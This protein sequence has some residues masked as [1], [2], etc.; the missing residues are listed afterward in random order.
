M[1]ARIGKNEVTEDL[2][3]HMVLNSIRS[4]VRQ[5]K[6]KYGKVVICCD[7]HSYWRRDF[8]PYYKHSRK[9]AREA[10]E[11]DWSTVF[12][13]FNKIKGELKACMPYYVLEVEGAEADDIIAVLTRRTCQHEPVLIL[14]SDKDFVQLQQHPNVIQYSPL[15]KSYVS[16]DNPHRYV[17]EHII[18]GDRGDGIPNFLS[19]DETF[20]IGERQKNINKTKLQEWIVGKPETFCTTVEMQHG[21]ARNRTLVDFSYIPDNIQTAIVEA[22]DAYTPANRNQMLNYFIQYR[23]KNLF[24]VAQDF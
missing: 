22:Y 10:S 8:F 13:M 3:R 17:R 15:L 5:H 23:L 4:Y 1:Q 14:S 9:K 21:Y 24:E 20:V 11:I 19:K 6:T 7:S 18:R 12:K 16:T 2:V